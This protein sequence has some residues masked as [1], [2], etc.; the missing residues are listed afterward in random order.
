MGASS[1]VEEFVVEFNQA[2]E[3]QKLSLSPTWNGIPG[4][5]TLGWDGSKGL[6][7]RKLTR[8][9]KSGA[10]GPPTYK[11]SHGDTSMLDLTVAEPSKSLI[12]SEFGKAQRIP[13][14]SEFD[15]V[16][17]AHDFSLG[18]RNGAAGTSRLGGRKGS[19]TAGGGEKGE[20][21][22]GLHGA[23]IISTLLNIV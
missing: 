4:L 10:S 5:K 6:S 15:S 8:E 7:V 2:S 3:Q 16:G 22:R 12:T 21:S 20:D 14:L 18:G 13:D 9:T 19:S 11:G 1:A 23:I 17:F